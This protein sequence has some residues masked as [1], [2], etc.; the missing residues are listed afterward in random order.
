[1]L[2]LALSLGKLNLSG[3][4]LDGEIVVLNEQGIPKFQLL[5]QAFEA[6]KPDAT[7][8]I[9]YYVFDIPFYLG[10]D[11]RNVPL[12]QRRASLES[13]LEKNHSANDLQSGPMQA[14]FAMV[15]LRG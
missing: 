6:K 8:A 13:L 1:M 4:W 15:C 11:L 2:Q 12:D 14:V 7:D 3:T 10:D 9:T 5:Q